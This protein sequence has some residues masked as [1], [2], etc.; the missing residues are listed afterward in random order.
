MPARIDTHHHILPPRYIAEL[1]RLG[2]MAAGGLTTFPPW[3]VELA[4]TTME[5]FGI[6]TAITS[7][8]SPGVYFGD[9]ASAKS[10]A[11]LCNDFS[12]EL[13]A[14]HPNRFGAFGTLPLPDVDGA[15]RE[16]EYVLD[17]LRLDGVVM[18]SSYG[19]MYPSADLMDSVFAELNRRRAVV[20]LHPTSPAYYTS[21][22]MP[23][24]SS[25][26][27]FVADTTRAV[28]HLLF[29]GVFEKYP[30]I[31]FILAHAGGTLPYIVSRLSIFEDHLQPQLR[32]KAPRGAAWYLKRLY[33]DTALATS[34][35]TLN[36]LREFTTALHTCFGTD[37]PF[38]CVDGVEAEIAEFETVMDGSAD[39]NTIEHETSIKLFPRLKSVLHEYSDSEVRVA[40]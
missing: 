5:R 25:L 32:E 29:S 22:E 11:R 2:V 7:I 18:L 9:V 21:G 6:S 27:E 28:L 4:L 36:C 24:A 10:L 13:T 39:R 40:L 14:A 20:F 15:L 38:V 34:R 19:T 31:R 37:Y 30:D 8:S 17:V 33:Y 1:N 23:F 16:L 35:P 3:S 12:A 26:F